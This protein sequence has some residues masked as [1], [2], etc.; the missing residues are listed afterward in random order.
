MDGME[1]R[2]RGPVFAT[3]KAAIARISDVVRSSGDTGAVSA[4]ELQVLASAGGEWRTIESWGGEVV[5]RI[6]RQ[7]AHANHRRADAR[8]AHCAA[9]TRL[10]GLVLLEAPPAPSVFE[11]PG[12]ELE[13]DLDATPISAALVRRQRRPKR[14]RWRLVGTAGLLVVVWGM[15]MYWMS[16]GNVT[17]LWAGPGATAAAAEELRWTREDGANGIPAPPA[18]RANVD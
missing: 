15:L 8:A 14:Q 3:A 16:G 1:R 11:L 10:E 2:P 18:S 12:V 17:A 5:A 7:A 13:A 6:G 4:V 9:L